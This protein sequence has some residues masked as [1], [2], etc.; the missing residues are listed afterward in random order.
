MNGVVGLSCSSWATQQFI[1]GSLPRPAIDPMVYSFIVQGRIIRRLVS[2]RYA[3]P[4]A[5]NDGMCLFSSMLLFAGIKFSKVIISPLG[6]LTAL[7]LGL[8]GLKWTVK[9]TAIP[10]M[11]QTLRRMVNGALFPY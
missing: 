6:V 4:P 5:G 7:G 8:H 9:I 2:S 3:F 1:V 10:P 11:Q